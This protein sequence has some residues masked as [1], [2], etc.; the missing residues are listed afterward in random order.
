[1]KSVQRNNSVPCNTCIC[2]ECECDRISCSISIARGSVRWRSYSRRYS[3]AAWTKV[4]YFA[5]DELIE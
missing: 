1:M 2:A 5:R 3:G 4:T